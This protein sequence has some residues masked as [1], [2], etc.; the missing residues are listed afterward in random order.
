MKP[1]LA[2]LLLSLAIAFGSSAHAANNCLGVAPP[3]MQVKFKNNSSETVY[4]YIEAPQIIPPLPLPRRADRADLWLQAQCATTLGTNYIIQPGD[5]FSRPFYHS[6]LIRA[7]INVQNRTSLGNSSIGQPPLSTAG[8]PPG[9]TA[10]ITLPFYTQMRSD[11]N[12]DNL[13]MVADQFIDWWNAV[14][15]VVFYRVEGAVSI[16]DANSPQPVAFNGSGPSALQPSCTTD[17]VGS[18]GC[19]ITYTSYVN[20]PWFGVGF[21]LQEFTLA[22]AEGPPPGGSASVFKMDARTLPFH[23]PN[24]GYNVSSLDSVY[25]PVA[26]GPITSPF[27]TSDSKTN[28]VGSG[29]NVSDFVG[30]VRAFSGQNA[31]GAGW[32][33]Y[34]PEYFDSTQTVMCGP[35]GNQQLCWTAFNN[36]PCS[37]N[38][39][40]RIP[41]QY[42]FPKIP[43]VAN[44]LLGSFTRDVNVNAVSNPP[45]LSGNPVNYQTLNGFANNLCRDF[46]PGGP[47]FINPPTLGTNG[48]QLFDLWTKC[49]NGTIPD[50]AQTCTNIK[51]I[52]KFFRDNYQ[53]TCGHQ[54]IASDD[55]L[56]VVYAV[57]G[58]VP[59][60]APLIPGPNQTQCAGPHL[61]SDKKAFDAAFAVYC[62]LQYNYL[63]LPAGN[64]QYIFNPY[65]Q[66]IHS[67][68][69]LN[70][71]AYAFS[72]DDGVSFRQIHGSPG[73]I[74]AFGGPSGLDFPTA[75]PVPNAIPND[76]ANYTKNCNPKG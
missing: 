56:S 4:V 49:N 67:P 28:Y 35:P 71:T 51:A 37:M 68:N 21:Q 60:I 66:L 70:S 19:F 65:A 8:I 69:L 46:Q 61:S 52:D 29:D 55:L 24:V 54:P 58:W 75:T 22:S 41:N 1:V 26:I 40:F 20:Q 44:M 12:E 45:I 15:M 10:T 47:P 2:S 18:P 33:Y 38:T 42:V 17:I 31:D 25:L 32:P 11:V 9:N 13:G 6:R 57:Y 48:Q 72:V 74:F 64:N 63:T 59:I 7:W 34:I 50:V 39:H 62:N 16:F 43:G 23:Y 36:A 14:R 5:T 76:P 53:M 27:I 3:T 73:I 30:K